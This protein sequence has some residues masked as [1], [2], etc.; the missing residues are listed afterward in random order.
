M[1]NGQADY[2]DWHTSFIYGILDFMW[3]QVQTERTAK[4]DQARGKRRT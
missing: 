4:N 3:N 1:V 2:S